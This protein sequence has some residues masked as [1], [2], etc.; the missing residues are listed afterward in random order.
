MLELCSMLH[1]TYYA[2]NYAGI[3]G[4]DL[5]KIWTVVGTRLPEVLL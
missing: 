1:P 5:S 3:M 2:P 4:T